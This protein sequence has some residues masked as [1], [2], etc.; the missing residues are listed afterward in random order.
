MVVDEIA[1]PLAQEPYDES[2]LTLLRDK[3][4]KWDNDHIESIVADDDLFGFSTEIDICKKDILDFCRFE[5]IGQ[6]SVYVGFLPV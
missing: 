3:V 6:G 1:V 5:M 4:S 2:P